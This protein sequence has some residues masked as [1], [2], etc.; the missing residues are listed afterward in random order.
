MNNSVNKMLLL[1]SLTICSTSYAASFDCKQAKSSTE[2]MICS[3]Y[4]LNRLDDFLDKNYK[5]AMNSVMPDNVK[6]KIKQSQVEWLGKR[7]TCG[8]AKCVQDMYSKRIDYLWDECFDYIRGRIEYVKYT[9][10]MDVINKE[11]N[12]K[13]NKSPEDIIK[14]FSV[15]HGGQI[16]DLGYTE[17]QLQSTIFINLDGYVKYSTLENYLSLMYE[18]PGFKSLD[19]IDY[20][21]YLGFRIKISGQPY[22]GFVLREED[23][24]LYLSGLVSGDEVI[25]P[26]TVRDV[27][28]LSSVFMNYASYAINKD[29]FNP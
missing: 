20:K 10:A 8:D 5:I 11:E 4:K 6:S 19:K 7:D 16:H 3:N 1:L 21:D 24:E 18:L 9:E 17:S 12:A 26:I 27:R 2:K 28:G 25:E 29:K 14:S 23:D 13:N 15:K 22:T